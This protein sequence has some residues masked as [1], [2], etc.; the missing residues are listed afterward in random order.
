MSRHNTDQ[1]GERILAREE[2]AFVEFQY[3]YRRLFLTHFLRERI[4]QV[5][6]E[7]LTWDCLTDIPLAAL[8]NWD[9]AKG[10]FDPWVLTLMRH[11]AANWWRRRRDLRVYDD[12]M[13]V[14][15]GPVPA[16]DARRIGELHEKLEQLAPGDRL[17]LE[18][19]YFGPASTYEEIAGELTRMR[20]DQRPVAAGTARVQHLRALKR[21]RALYGLEVS[22]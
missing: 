12:S 7:D 5:D 17:I 10:P 9:P 1:L 4:P 14:P 8:D 22:K 19:R 21:L 15:D 18:L 2:D 3:M 20:D 11:A 13:H 6:A 16:P